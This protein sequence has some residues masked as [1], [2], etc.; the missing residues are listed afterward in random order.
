MW[1]QIRLLLS[2]VVGALEV[3]VALGL[4]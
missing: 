1:Q 3:A 4:L 2:L